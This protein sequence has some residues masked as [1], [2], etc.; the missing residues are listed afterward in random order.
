MPD[1]GPIADLLR[2]IVGFSA[3]RLMEMEVGAA[4]G[5]AYGL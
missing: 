3:E 5:P 2:E 4:T 1:E